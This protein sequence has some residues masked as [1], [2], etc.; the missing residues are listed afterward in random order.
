MLVVFL[1]GK[2]RHAVGQRSIIPFYV[3]PCQTAPLTEWRHRPPTIVGTG[4][5]QHAYQR[6]EFGVTFPHRDEFNQDRVEGMDTWLHPHNLLD[7]L[8]TH[9]LT[10]SFS[11]TDVELCAA[12]KRDCRELFYWHGLN[13]NLAWISNYKCYRVWDD[14]TYPFPNFNGQ[15]SKLGI[16]WVISSH[17]LLDMW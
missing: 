4:Y 9:A 1:N 17:T 2:S 8:P 5:C 13:L 12:R 15:L 14:I 11:Q 16:G 7:A 3:A 6:Q 10:S